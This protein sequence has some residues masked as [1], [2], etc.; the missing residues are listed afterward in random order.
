M[1]GLRQ[2]GQAAEPGERELLRVLCHLEEADREQGSL[3]ALWE[4]L[5]KRCYPGAGT[6]PRADKAAAALASRGLITRQSS[7][8][9]ERY[10]IRPEVAAAERAQADPAFQGTVD[11]CVAEFWSYGYRSALGAQGDAVDAGKLLWTATSAA[12]Y[13]ARLGYW[14]DVFLMLDGAFRAGP[15]NQAAS[16][17]LDV[18]ITLR[19]FPPNVPAG[20]SPDEAAQ[21][22][23]SREDVLKLGR[24]RARRLSRWDDHLEL[25]VALDASLRERGASPAEIARSRVWDYLPLYRTGR[26]DAALALLAE[27]HQAFDATS[28]VRGLELATSF[29]AE[30]HA[31][32]HNA[33]EALADAWVALRYAFMTG[34]ATRVAIAYHNL[35]DYTAA[36]LPPQPARLLGCYLAAAL[37]RLVTGDNDGA[38][39]SIRAA[40]RV[41]QAAG[42]SD[43]PLQTVEELAAWAPAMP[44]CDLAALVRRLS[45]GFTKDPLRQVI[46]VTQLM[47]R[48]GP[49]A[50]SVSLS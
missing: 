47:A 34:D 1:A 38:S 49:D 12:S 9:R 7:G 40:A 3:A 36:F 28:D 8:G 26:V 30:V 42:I 31:R 16:Q 46:N 5:W 43:L 11:A 13:V 29:R 17:V 50:V 48:L 18:V 22:R 27:C 45:P 37:L 25:S 35:G 20:S 44:D 23:R 10:L 14:D 32:Q 24:D 41:V 39:R 33:D 19:S 6:P 4:P 2:G 15:D 21:Q